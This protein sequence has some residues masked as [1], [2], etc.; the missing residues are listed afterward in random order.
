MKKVTITGKVVLKFRQVINVPE[1]ELDE[2]MSS[3]EN[4]TCNVD[5]N[6]ADWDIEE[7]EDVDASV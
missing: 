5:L 7:F 1:D 4:I 6:C 3:E 2:F